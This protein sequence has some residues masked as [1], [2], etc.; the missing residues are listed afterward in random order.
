[1]SNHRLAVTYGKVGMRLQRSKRGML[2]VDRVGDRRSQ[3]ILAR[4]FSLENGKSAEQGKTG[5]FEKPRPSCSACSQFNRDAYSEVQSSAG[6]EG[7]GSVAAPSPRAPQPCS[8][9]ATAMFCSTPTSKGD[10]SKVVSMGTFLMSVDIWQ[11]FV[12]THKILGI[13]LRA[14]RRTSITGRAS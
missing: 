14:F 13:D 5:K 4:N 9:C 6:R 12:L 1:V 8:Y 10:T 2:G 7:R 11:D 3:A